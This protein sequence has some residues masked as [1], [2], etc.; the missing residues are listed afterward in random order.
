MPQQGMATGVAQRADFDAQGRPITAGGFVKT[1]PVVFQ[2][3]AAQ[4]GLATWRNVTGTPQKRVI[5]EAK[6]SGVCL[7]DFDHDGWLDIY[8]VTGSTF[9]A[10]SGKQQ[11][12]HAALFRNNHDGAGEWAVQLATTTTMAG[13]TST[14]PISAAT[15]STTTT[16]TAPSP[17]WRRKPAWPSTRP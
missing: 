13:P 1:G 16:A 15:V 5:I 7:L 17:M 8:L 3:V 2:N 9:D 11:P 4:A 10:Q 14:S 12:P 6:G